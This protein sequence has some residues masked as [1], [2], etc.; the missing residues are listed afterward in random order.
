MGGH[1]TDQFP[2][3]LGPCLHAVKGRLGQEIWEEYVCMMQGFTG[4]Y[5][6]FFVLKNLID[7]TWWDNRQN[8]CILCSS[9]YY[10]KQSP[11]TLTNFVHF[12]WAMA[13][14]WPLRVKWGFRSNLFATKTKAS[15]KIW[16]AD[17]D[18]FWGICNI[19]HS[20]IWWDT[21]CP[22]V[23]KWGPLSHALWAS[24]PQTGSGS[25]PESGNCLLSEP[26]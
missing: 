6:F 22:S 18:G 19:V 3:Y 24:R 2:F 8:I 4:S 21:M 7:G 9:R 1:R 20:F 5:N 16:L 26:R 12:D 11:V 14:N 10:L 17:E 25:W 15:C 13:S 23:S